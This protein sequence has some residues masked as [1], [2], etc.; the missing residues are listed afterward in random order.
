MDFEK[1]VLD[2]LDKIELKQIEHTVALSKNT[3]IL[4]EHH[5]RTTNLEARIRPI[6]NHKHFVDMFTKVM[7]G[8]VT[9]AAAGAALYHYLFK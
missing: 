1:I 4:T 3:L 2:K 6:E 7:I 9:T 5:V 8:I